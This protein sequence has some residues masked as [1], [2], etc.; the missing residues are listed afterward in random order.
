M[1]YTHA[2][3]QRHSYVVYTNTQDSTSRRRA[4]IFAWI[5]VALHY[6]LYLSFFNILSYTYLSV[7]YIRY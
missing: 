2:Y 5:L 6:P 4:I 7:I 3:T 1:R